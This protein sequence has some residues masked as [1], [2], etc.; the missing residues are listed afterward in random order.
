M[1]RIYNDGERVY[2]HL[3]NG[4]RAFYSDDCMRSFIKDEIANNGRLK[5]EGKINVR[6]KQVLCGCGNPT[7]TFISSDEVD[8]KTFTA[9][10]PKVPRKLPP[11][12]KHPKRK[13]HPM[14]SGKIIDSAPVKLTIRQKTAYKNYPIPLIGSKNQIKKTLPKGMKMKGYMISGDEEWV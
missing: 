7:C 8:K 5:R 6:H 12:T 11:P 10:H 13:E 9:N 2:K 14:F 3:R 4:G 1:K